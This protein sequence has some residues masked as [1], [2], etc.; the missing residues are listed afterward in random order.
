[1][2]EHA[3]SKEFNRL[4]Q[5]VRK[6]AKGIFDKAEREIVLQFVETSEIKLADRHHAG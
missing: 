5:K 2:P 3:G 4:A 1:M 6:I